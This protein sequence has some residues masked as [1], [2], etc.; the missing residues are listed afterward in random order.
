VCGVTGREPVTD[1]LHPHKYSFQTIFLV[2][3]LNEQSLNT[4]PIR[5]K[6]PVIDSG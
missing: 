1:G 5:E 6:K 2:C 3:Y 4:D